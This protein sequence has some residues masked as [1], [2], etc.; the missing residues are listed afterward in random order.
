MATDTS[1]SRPDAL[2]APP[3]VIGGGVV[4]LLGLLHVFVLQVGDVVGFAVLLV[5][6]PLVGGS[7]AD[8]LSTDEETG[9][10]RGALSGAFGALTVALVV[11]LTG[12][13]GVWPTF[14]TANIGVSV[15][16]VTFAVL[17]MLLLSWTVFSY[18][19]SHLAERLS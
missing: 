9:H 7:V 18:V 15:W 14:I 11:L 19:G 16:P 1:R 6:W 8:R 13:A 10:L 3:D 4:A 17:L 5:G 2:P 12:L